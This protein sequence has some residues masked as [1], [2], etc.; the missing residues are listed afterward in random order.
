MSFWF[1]HIQWRCQ[2]FQFSCM[3]SGDVKC[4]IL[5][6]DY[7]WRCPMSHFIILI[8]EMS[9]IPDHNY[10]YYII[11]LWRRQISETEKN[12]TVHT[13]L[14][15]FLFRI[16]FSVIV[17]FYQVCTEKKRRKNIFSNAA[18]RRYLSVHCTLQLSRI[19]KNNINMY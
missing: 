17:E 8:V 19:K 12:V 9:T 7:Q 18:Q 1:S 10:Y 6:H 16:C 11:L 13:Y 3:I 14:A 5:S 15:K 4:P 2:M